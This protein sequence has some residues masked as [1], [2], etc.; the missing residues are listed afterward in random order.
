MVDLGC[1]EIC[2]SN[3]FANKLGVPKE[4]TDMSAELWDK[5]LVPMERCTEDIILNI[6]G[7]KF[8]IKPFIVDLIACDVIFEQ[9]CLH[10]LNPLINWALNR[11]LLK[12]DGRIITLNA[13]D[14]KHGNSSR[15]QTPTSKQFAKLVRKQKSEI[16]YVMLKPKCMDHL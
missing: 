4:S 13:E 3:E 14:C 12:L 5:T 16:Y 15:I 2:I 8:N 6:R 7:A 9:S 10:E 11:M 1:Q